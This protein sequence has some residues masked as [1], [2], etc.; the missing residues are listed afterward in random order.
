MGLIRLGTWLQARGWVLV[1]GKDTAPAVPIQMN[2]ST[3]GGEVCVSQVKKTLPLQPWL[4][5]ALGNCPFALELTLCT[6]IVPLQD[7]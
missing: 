5:N 4:K 3:A 6:G 2:D 1:V 7:P